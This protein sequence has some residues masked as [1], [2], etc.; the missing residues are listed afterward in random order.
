MLTG[1]VI[2]L[3]D[4]SKINDALKDDK[5]PATFESFIRYYQ[6]STNKL[7]YISSII[8]TTRV[9][10]DTSIKGKVDSLEVRKCNCW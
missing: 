6:T 8:E 5:K 2:D 9:L 3:L 10:T 1:E 4:I 7:F